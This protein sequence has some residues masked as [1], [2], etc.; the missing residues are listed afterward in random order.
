MLQKSIGIVLRTQD[1]GETHKLVTIFTKD[2]GKIT[3]ISRGANKPRSRL[4]A[5]SQ[6][7][8]EAEFLLYIPK[9]LATL[10]QGDIISTF[11][12]IRTDLSRTAYAAYIIELTDRIVEEKNPDPYIYAELNRTLHYINNETDYLIPIMMYEMK[13]FQK[14]GF[15]PIVN[16]CVN[17]NQ[18]ENFYGFSVQEGGILCERCAPIDRYAVQLPPSLFRMLAIFLHVE[19]DR[20]GKIKVKEENITKLRSLFDQYYDRYGGYRLKS[21]KFL[22]D[23][24]KLDEK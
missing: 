13:L 17:C 12:H 10:R 19:L 15:A 22:D 7:F 24:H 9:G 5:V 2:I 3:A 20:V 4:S 23:L 6:L 16:R 18:T 21:K 1:Y 11:R 14:G 8:I